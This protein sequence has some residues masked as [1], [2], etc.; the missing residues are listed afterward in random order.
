MRFQFP[1]AAIERKAVLEQ[2]LS[3]ASRGILDS[4]KFPLDD[5]MCGPQIV[6]LFDYLHTF[7]DKYDCESLTEKFL[8]TVF[9]LLPKVLWGWQGYVLGAL[10][11]ND[12]LCSESLTV[13]AAPFG[14]G[15]RIRY[16]KVE[17]VDHCSLWKQ[18]IHA[19]SSLFGGYSSKPTDCPMNI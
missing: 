14:W 1:D 8:A 16:L 6:D 15:E 2:F 7:L 5:G 11:R 13:Y 18:L 19:T 3:L 12:R 9:E 10:W 17:H 4:S